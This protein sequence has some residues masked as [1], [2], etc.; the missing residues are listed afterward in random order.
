M[1]L[2]TEDELIQAY[3]AGRK[4][5][6]MP[7]LPGTKLAQVT[8]LQGVEYDGLYFAEDVEKSKENQ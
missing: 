1:T 5:E 4:K 2:Y 3:V 6:S 8:K 7:T